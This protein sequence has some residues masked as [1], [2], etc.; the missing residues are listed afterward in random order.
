MNIN[1]LF[2]THGIKYRE[3]NLK[4]KLKNMSDDEKLE[5][6][7]SD[8]MLVKRPLAISGNHL[9]LG[10][11]KMSINTNGYRCDIKLEKVNINKKYKLKW[12]FVYLKTNF[13]SFILC[14][15]S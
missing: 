4:E 9:T 12:C 13:N 8:G 1:K 14:N 3:L 6:L 10:F 5:L 7:A 2:N 15:N 11:K